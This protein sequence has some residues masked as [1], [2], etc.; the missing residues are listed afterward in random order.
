MNITITIS[1][2][3]TNPIQDGTKIQAHDELEFPA[4]TLDAWVARNKFYQMQ[5]ISSHKRPT[6]DMPTAGSKHLLDIRI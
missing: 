1:D 4:E 5:C 2:E 6:L 3:R